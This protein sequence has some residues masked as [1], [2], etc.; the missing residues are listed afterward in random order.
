MVEGM[1][2]NV[3][4][5]TP[6]RTPSMYERA[7]LV[8][9]WMGNA[10]PGRGGLRYLPKDIGQRSSLRGLQTTKQVPKAV[11]D[12][13][14]V[15]AY[16]Q[17]IKEI[18]SKPF[19]FAEAQPLFKP[20]GRQGRDFLQF[21]K[22]PKTGVVANVREMSFSQPEWTGPGGHINWERMNPRIRTTPEEIVKL[23][24]DLN[25]YVK[26]KFGINWELTPPHADPLTR[27]R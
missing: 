15:K 4:D 24:Q 26:Q 2:R 19:D 25:S 22:D 27:S 20:T 6:E 17:D 21:A 10:L 23:N 1:R 8:A 11:R 14:Q 9:D 12:P 16:K 13:A 5:A 7:S 3:Q 18:P